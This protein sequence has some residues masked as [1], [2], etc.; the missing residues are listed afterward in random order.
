MFEDVLANDGSECLVD[1]DTLP[2]FTKI[3]WPA[4]CF[5]TSKDKNSDSVHC[6]DMQGMPGDEWIAARDRPFKSKGGCRL[7]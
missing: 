7:S 4:H 5:Y 2:D 6:V 3:K 1:V